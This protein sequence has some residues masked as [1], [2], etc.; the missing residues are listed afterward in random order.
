MADELNEVKPGDLITAEQFNALIQ[1][2]KALMAAGGGPIVVP[3][4]F[5]QTLQNAKA[6]ILF[7]G[8]HLTLGTTLDAF[9]NLINVNDAGNQ[10]LRVI[11][12]SPPPGTRVLAN[13]AVALLVA[14]RPSATTPPVFAPVITGFDKTAVPIG[15]QLQIMGSNF[16]SSPADNQV[17]F[18]NVAAQ[19]PSPMSNDKNLFVVVPQG[20]PV[21]AGVVVKV[22]TP[23]G[24]DTDTI[25]IQPATNIVRPTIASFSRSIAI[26]GE[27]VVINGTNFGTTPAAVRVKFTGEPAAG[28]TVKAAT[29]TTVTVT[30]PT[31]LSGANPDTTKKFV[32]TVIVNN[33]ESIP[34]T[35]SELNIYTRPT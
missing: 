20:T 22:K 23:S 15:E 14:A 7:P 26:V 12:Q 28:Q 33:V 16:A 2:V 5:G 8:A 11:G 3:S 17:S 27:D 1:Q 32:V 13:T 21:Q 35:K 10:L 29:G 34:D 19:S 9:G 25:T 31:G 4:L 6:I 18:G 30:V 24:E